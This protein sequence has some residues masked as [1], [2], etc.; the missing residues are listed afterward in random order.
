MLVE[1]RKI[2]TEY[3]RVSKNKKSHTYTR[4]KTIHIL[5]C[6]CCNTMFE[7]EQGTMD[8]KRA[9]ND[10]Q[11]VCPNC[12]PKKFAQKVGVVNRNFWNTP[13]GS[14]IKI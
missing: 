14:D 1:T 12:N 10:F 5:C 8:R 9:T 6:D 2:K 13:A 3:T 11:H 4:Y 7:R